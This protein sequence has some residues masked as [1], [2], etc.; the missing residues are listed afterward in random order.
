M[1]AGA[2]ST[3]PDGVASTSRGA[4]PSA[5][6]RCRAAA[7]STFSSVS[8]SGPRRSGRRTGPC[9]SCRSSRRSGP[10][11]VVAAR[12]IVGRVEALRLGERGEEPVVDRV[13]V[14]LAR[15]HARRSSPPSGSGSPTP[16]GR[17]SAGGNT[18]GE[19]VAAAAARP[20]SPDQ[21]VEVRLLERR[22]AR[23]GSRARAASSR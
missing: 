13:D 22:Q 20:T 23:A 4:A 18:G 14:D 15:R 9:G 8:P 19:Y 2:S 6:G 11:L 1:Y 21:V 3:L 10:P 12:A 17:P 7:P 5:R 16:A